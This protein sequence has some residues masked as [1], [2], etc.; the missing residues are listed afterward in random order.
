[1]AAAPSWRAEVEEPQK[2]EPMDG[3]NA[4]VFVGVDM[5]KTEHYA[6]AITTDGVE[7]L[8]MCWVQGQ[9]VS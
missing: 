3:P 2:G 1:M 4:D 9:V 8:R 6:Q 5:A 7:A